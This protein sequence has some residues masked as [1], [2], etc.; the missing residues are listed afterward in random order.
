MWSLGCRQHLFYPKAGM[1]IQQRSQRLSNL[2]EKPPSYP[3]QREASSL[4][5]VKGLTQ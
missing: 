3:Q 2:L 4:S 5:L 1:P